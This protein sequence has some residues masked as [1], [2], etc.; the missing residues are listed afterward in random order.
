MYLWWNIGMFHPLLKFLAKSGGRKRTCINCWLWASVPVETLCACPHRTS[1]TPF[2]GGQ[3][4]RHV[5][6]LE[7]KTK[8]EEEAFPKVGTA[9]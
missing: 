3:C 8:K 2:W 6:D 7:S 4:Y 9:K 5:F 1:R